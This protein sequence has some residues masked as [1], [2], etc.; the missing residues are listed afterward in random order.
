EEEISL[1]EDSIFQTAFLDPGITEEVYKVWVQNKAYGYAGN[2]FGRLWTDWFRIRNHVT[3]EPLSHILSEKFSIE[4]SVFS[5]PFN[6][7]ESMKWD[8]LSLEKTEPLNT[9]LNITVINADTNKTLVGFD[10]L[11][12]R[13]IDLTSLNDQGITNIRLQGLLAGNESATPLLRSWGVEWTAENVWRD[14]FIGNRKL[15]IVDNVKISNDV[16][17]SGLDEIGF[18]QS[19]LIFLPENMSW[20][21]LQ[22][23]RS[24]PEATTLDIQ[25][26][27]GE[28][29]EILMIGRGDDGY[30]YLDL[31]AIDPLGN[32]AIYL[33]ANFKS[34][35]EQVPVLY[36]WGIRIS[37]DSLEPVAVAGKDITIVQHDLVYFDG[38]SSYDN[39]GIVNFTW[40]FLYKQKVENLFGMNAEFRFENA[41][42]FPVT[43]IVFDAAGYLGTDEII[44]TVRDTTPPLA[45]GGSN[46]AVPQSTDVVFNASASTDNTGIMNFSWS[47]V[48]DGEIINLYGEETS[49]YFVMPGIYVIDLKLIDFNNN[50]AEDSFVLHVQDII[51]PNAM[52]GEDMAAQQGELIRF[53]GTGSS[54]NVGIDNYTWLF[55]DN[56]NV[57]VLYGGNVSHVLMTPGE[58]LVTLVVSDSEKNIDMDYL[59]LIVEEDD[60]VSGE[61]G[62]DTDGDGWNDTYENASGSDPNDRRSTPLD[63]DGDG[64]RNEWDAYP[65]DPKRWLK[66]DGIMKNLDIAIF[67]GLGM[68]LFLICFISYSRISQ[69]NIFKHRTRVNICSYVQNHP[70]VYFRELSRRMNIHSSTLHHHIRKLED[71]KVINTVSDGYFMRCYFGEPKNDVRSLTPTQEKMLSVISKNSGITYKQLIQKTNLTYPTISYHVNS[72]LDRGVVTKVK[73]DGL[74]HLFLN[75]N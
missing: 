48:Y 38:S 51:K 53:N 20:S 46:L 52:A 2:G 42:S 25:V 16:R 73:N 34:T 27:N 68:I 57:V 59:T 60:E 32:K 26:H 36:D 63:W 14:S 44:V 71:A 65:R 10:N 3:P 56:G 9:Y 74:I 31:T 49:F 33:R 15:L 54:D 58:Y 64:I 21:A 18:V 55:F 7:P 37:K 19:E 22:V 29:D 8:S 72:L 70:G 62:T 75:K 5:K 28:T 45:D 61:D 4:G 47:F 66:E 12:D 35:N 67:I 40:I 43:L 30:L 41:G 1:F 11:P 39:M 13:D 6:I 50:Q 23:H 69:K 24:V 17:P